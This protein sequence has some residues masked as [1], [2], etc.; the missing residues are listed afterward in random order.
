MLP[1]ISVIVTCYNYGKYLE[2][3]LRSLLNQKNSDEFLYE[4][5]VI[6]DCS[7]DNTPIVIE[8]FAK[9]FPQ[10]IYHRNVTNRGLPSSCNIGI[11]KSTGR[12]VVRVDADDY[13]SRNFL[14][15]F[16]T[17]LDKNKNYQAY[18][19]DYMDVD[20]FENVIRY[21]SA[22]EEEIACG[23][24][25]RREF[26]L[27]IGLYDETY[28]Y[29]E[30]HDLNFRFKQKYKIGYIELPMYFARKHD[31]NRSSNKKKIEEFSKR[32]GKKTK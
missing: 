18:A 10:I 21:V 4:I 16:K 23:V 1:D 3:C 32:V 14:F 27:D 29:R 19:C 11:D 25:Y 17:F 15:F 26:I 30:G 5:I 28:E 8:K 2:R 24:M 12:Y 22:K 7:S 20:I 6:D 31:A 13:V 9:Q